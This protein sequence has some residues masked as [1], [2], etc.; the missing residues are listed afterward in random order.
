MRR[1]AL[2]LGCIAGCAGDGSST[3][4]TDT[5]T[6]TETSTGFGPSTSGEP[7][8]STGTS[9]PSDSMDED[10][11]T[12]ASQSG[13][14]SS[15]SGS[16]ESTGCPL[17]TLGCPCDEGDRPCDKGLECADDI[18]A[19]PLCDEKE[20]EN[21]DAFNDAWNLGEFDDGAPAQMFSSSLSGTRDIDW[22]TYTC[23]DTLFEDLVPTLAM[24]LQ[25]PM[26]VCFYIDCVIGGNPL[27][28]CPEGTTPEQAPIDFIPGCCVDDAS[29]IDLSDYNCPDSDNDSVRVYIEA[30][31]ASSDTCIGYTMTYT[32]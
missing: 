22:F 17:G 5:E 18:C 27:F 7:S 3:G 16:S 21:N 6:E 31:M 32:C 25:M 9:D 30:E 12:L 2:L 26:R 29:N 19:E 8:T 10:T 11:T 28:E 23:N 13:E 15:S 4:D 20:F 14:G 1:W 24:D